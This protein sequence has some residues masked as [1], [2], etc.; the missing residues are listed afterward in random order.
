MRISPEDADLFFKL[1]PAL[2]TFA[3][4]KLQ[5]IQNLN[6]IKQYQTISNQDRVNLR[7]AFYEKPYIIDE[8]VQKN[9]YDFTPDELTIVSGWKNFI[10]GDFFIQSVTKKYA[11][12]I[13]HNK[14]YG[15]LALIEPFQAV[16]GGM[17]FPAYVK[18]V[19][20]PF[21]RKIIYDGLIEGYNLFIGSGMSAS[22]RNTY[23]GK[24]TR[25]DYRES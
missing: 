2:Q 20:L 19:L 5:L 23:R 4:Q 9:P 22:F 1:M 10:A 16:L 13:G 11:I 12:F 7:N 15:V 3:N 24:T 17:P 8:F 25:Q 21:K 18:T 14:V 6:D